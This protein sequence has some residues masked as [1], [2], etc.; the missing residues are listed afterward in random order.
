[1]TATSIGKAWNSSHSDVR[2]E[3]DVRDE[4]GPPG[5]DLAHQ[6]AEHAL[7]ERVG[8][9]LVLLDQRAQAR[10]V[11]DVAAD[12]PPLE[13]GQPELAEA[14]L[15]EVADADD[16]HCGQV[17][18]P[19]LRRVDVGQLVDEALR[20]GVA[21]ARA[22]DQQRAAVLDESD[23]FADADELGHRAK[24]SATYATNPGLCTRPIDGREKHPVMA[25]T[26]RRSG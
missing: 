11:A 21:S 25:C 17:A 8:L 2:A 13:A 23:C 16:A 18:R 5:G 1:M 22:T 10:L 7:G 9:D 14:T 6:L 20:Q 3:P 15:G 12:R 24:A 26:P 4:P 19:A